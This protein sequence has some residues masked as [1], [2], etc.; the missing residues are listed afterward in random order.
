MNLTFATR[1]SELARWQTAFVMRALEAAHPGLTCREQVFVTRGDRTLD[2]ALPQIGGKGLFTQE[3]EAALLDGRADA[4][5]HSLK[6]LPTINPDGLTL[7]A[8]PARADARDALVSAAG[9]TIESLPQGARVGTSSP[10]RRAQILRQRP[11]LQVADIRGNVDTRLRKLFDG[12]YDAILLAVAGL[13]R[14]GLDARLGEQMQPFSFEQMLPAPG[15]GALAVQCRAA[16][17]EILPILQ[18]IED[19]AT[20]LAVTAERAFLAGLGGGCAVP[21]AAHAQVTVSSESA[22]RIQL[23]GLV[24]APDGHAVIRMHGEGAEPD[25]LGQHLAEEALNRGAQ[26]LLQA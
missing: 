20:R 11:D 6:D 24:A 16:D 4:A 15:Q 22:P 19:P 17:P 3:L 12:Q 2:R 26:A 1:P 7:G 23:A 9:Y 18:A 8:I 13:T 14:L 25:A 5:V 21:I 10:R